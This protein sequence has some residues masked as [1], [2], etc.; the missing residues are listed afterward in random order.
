MLAHSIAPLF[1][2]IRRSKKPRRK[3]PRMRWQK[4]DGSNARLSPKLNQRRNFSGPR[5]IISVTWK[6]A[7]FR[8]ARFNGAR[9]IRPAPQIS[10][11]ALRR[12]YA[13]LGLCGNGQAGFAVGK[14]Y[15]YLW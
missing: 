12:E 13:A 14:I 5:N 6:S 7:V 8:I 11:R 3:N 9:I 15:F 4:A 10:D 1:F 2:I